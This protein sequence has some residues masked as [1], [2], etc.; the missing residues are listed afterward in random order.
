MT[1]NL[2]IPQRMLYQIPGDG[3]QEGGC[4]CVKERDRE[5]HGSKDTKMEGQSGVEEKKVIRSSRI[6]HFT[7]TQDQQS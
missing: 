4:V 5:T 1:E 6:A 3:D 2:L 7:F